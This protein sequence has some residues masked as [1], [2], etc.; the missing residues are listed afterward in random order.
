VIQYDRLII[1]IEPSAG[2]QGYQVSVEGE[3]G[4]GHGHFELPF[5][6]LDIE[7]FVLRMS[8]GRRTRRVETSESERAKWFGRE[9]FAALFQGEVRDVYRSCL[10]DARRQSRGLRVTLALTKV[11]ELMDVPW[12][13]LYDE[14][15]FLAVSVWTPVVR[16]LDVAR[17]K[18]PLPVSPPLRVLGMISDVV[19]LPRLD[20]EGERQR[21]EAALRP[22]RSQGRVEV[23]WTQAATLDSLLRKLHHGD[24]HIL[25]FVGHGG[26]DEAREDGVLLFQGPDGRSHEITGER[27]ATILQDHRSLRLVVLNACEGARSSQSDPFAGVAA[28]LVQRGIPAVVAMQ[29]EITDDAAL[30]FAAYFYEALAQGDP[31]DGAV[32]HAR[33]GIFASGNDVEW[34]TPVLF[35]RS[36]DGRVFDLQG[37]QARSQEAELSLAFEAHPT[38]AAVG[39]PIT[40]LL[41]IQN[42]GKPSLFRATPR[43]DAGRPLGNPVDLVSG[44]DAVFTWSSTAELGPPATVSVTASESNGCEVRASAQARLDVEPPSAPMILTLRPEPARAGIGEDIQW[45]LSVRATG[46][47]PLSDVVAEDAAGRKLNSPIEVPAAAER[48]VHWTSPARPTGDERVLVRA[49]DDRGRALSE[50]VSATVTVGESRADVRAGVGAWTRGMA[51]VRKSEPLPPGPADAPSVA[52]H[53]GDGDAGAGREPV[54]AGWLRRRRELAIGLFALLACAVPVAVILLSDSSQR[55][56]ENKQL[57]REPVGQRLTGELAPVPT[58]HVE[59][60]GRATVRLNGTLATVSVNATGLLNNVHAM[61]IHAGGPGVCPLGTAAQRHNGHIAISAVDGV[62]WYGPP[63]VALTTSGDTTRGSIEAFARYKTGR[64]LRYTRAIGVSTVMAARIR[65]DNAVLVVHGIDWNRNGTYDDR[66]G[67]YDNPGLNEKTAPA[68]CGKLVAQ[69]PSGSGRTKTAQAPSVTGTQ[70]FTA[71]LNVQRGAGSSWLCH[72]GAPTQGD[73]AGA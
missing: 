43:D 36:A 66:A 14:P 29:F 2:Q 60:V 21:L 18:A 48:D 58:N 19:D 26:Y 35:L 67:T 33:L 71:S 30:T 41:H 49:C 52:A 12:E 51:R 16:Y 10:A 17:P 65:T 9:L 40:W 6:G 25:H 59:G 8:R 64:D 1:R 31:V 27:L 73:R 45:R 72:L 42:V 32:A 54:R 5:G 68:L 23:H 70:V 50:S 28:S 69:K 39:E 4:E 34:G 63:V 57:S 56:T 22:L 62:R 3:E 24:F 47:T 53:D 46:P 7:N 37:E 55:P 44:E 11:P 38:V 61:H 20:V 15:D 13:Y